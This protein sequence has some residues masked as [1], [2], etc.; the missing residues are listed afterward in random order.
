MQDIRF[1]FASLHLV[2]FVPTSI[3]WVPS[4]LQTSKINSFALQYTRVNISSAPGT[5]VSKCYSWMQINITISQTN[6][7]MYT[8]LIVTNSLIFFRLNFDEYSS[9]FHSLSHALSESNFRMQSEEIT[10]PQVT[11]TTRLLQV[12]QKS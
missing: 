1:F 6:T 8:C 11:I 5:E 10:Q 3:E 9:F 7:F 4:N 12:Q 2:R